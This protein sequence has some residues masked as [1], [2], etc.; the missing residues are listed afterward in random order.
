MSPI[1]L[2]ALAF[3]LFI[4]REL[5]VTIVR[6]TTH[7]MRSEK[8]IAHWPM[9]QDPHNSGCHHPGLRDWKSRNAGGLRPLGTVRTNRALAKSNC[10]CKKE[11]FLFRLTNLSS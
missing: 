4:A 5:H 2:I 1:L 6:P 3:R 7:P 9:I 8:S 11:G 10:S